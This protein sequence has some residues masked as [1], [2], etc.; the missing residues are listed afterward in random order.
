MQ[1]LNLVWTG[2]FAW[3][4]NGK[5]D[6]KDVLLHTAPSDRGVYL[7]TVPFQSTEMHLVQIAGITQ[8][9]RKR[10]R[11]HHRA[12]WKGTY[13][14]FDASLMMTGQ[15]TKLWQGLWNRKDT[16]Q[17]RLA[18]KNHSPEVKNSLNHLLATYRIFFGTFSTDVEKRIP[19]RTEYAIM[20]WLY[21]QSSPICD[22]PD[23][24]M[25]LSPRWPSE[26]PIKLLMKNTEMI[27]GL[28]SEIII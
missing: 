18:F 7:W 25:A 15:R 23:R 8:S 20:H 9:F 2:P 5:D 6:F 1:N 19:K 24:G 10:F 17:Q 11:E 27:M 26:P 3:P 21:T 4:H 14:V 12:Y 16:L 22:I 28:P 13:S